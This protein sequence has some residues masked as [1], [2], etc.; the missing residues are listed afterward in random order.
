MLVNYEVSLKSPRN[1]V[2]SNIIIKTP[3]LP[4]GGHSQSPKCSSVV[5]M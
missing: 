5:I 4:L 2:S 3:F 1:A